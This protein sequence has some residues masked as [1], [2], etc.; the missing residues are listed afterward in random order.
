MS[1]LS[2]IRSYFTK[3][4]QSG[5]PFPNAWTGGETAYGQWNWHNPYANTA[6]NYKRAMGDLTGSSLLMAAVNWAGMAF[7]EA[8]LQV[9]E[10]KSAKIKEPIENHPMIDLLE[11]PTRYQS[12]NGPREYFA[13]EL[14]W[15]SFA[16]SYI[17]DGNVYFRKV[18]NNFG[19]VIQLWPENSSTIRP[20]WPKDGSE[21]ISYYEVIRNG[22]WYRVG[23]PNGTADDV[24]HFRYA[25]PTGMTVDPLNDRLALSPV[26]S[27]YREIFTDGE[28]A[29]YNALIFKNGGVIPFLLTPDPANMAGLKPKEIKE[30]F[31]YRMGGD[32][33]GRP[34]VLT[35]AAKLTAMGATPDQLLI[36][37][38][39]W[40]PATRVAAALGIPA[41]VLG[42]EPGLE[43]TKVG[44]PQP[45]SAR[46]WT[47]SGATTMG[48]VEVGDMVATP[49]GWNP[50]INT[51]DQGEQDIYR[52]T[53]QDSSTAESTIDHLWEVKSPNDREYRTLPLSKIAKFPWWKLRYTVLPLQGVTE[54]DEQMVMIPPYL[55]G[56]LISDGSFRGNVFF[57]NL[58]EEVVAYAKAEVPD[59][60][61]V[62]NIQFGDYLIS[63]RAASQG[64]GKG[65]GSGN[66]NPMKD[67]LRRLGLWMLYSYEKFIPDVYKYNSSEVR[68]DLLRGI[69]D[70]DGFVNQHGQPALEQTSLRLAQDVTWLVQSL[71][72]YTLQSLKKV[73]RNTRLIAGRP[74][75]SNHDRYHLSIVIDDAASLFRYSGKKDKC[76]PRIKPATRKF[77]SIELVRREET[78]CLQLEDGLYLTDSFLVTHNTMRELREQAA[79]SFL[80]PHYRVMAGELQS[81]LLPEFGDTK[82]LIVAHDLSQVRVLQDDRVALFEREIKA[83]DSGVKTRAEVKSAL[84]IDTTP[85][86]EVYK[87]RSNETLISPDERSA[88]VAVPAVPFGNLAQPQPDVQGKSV[89]LGDDELAG[90]WW[91]RYAPD[92]APA[93][94]KRVN[95][96]A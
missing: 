18:R 22:V 36:E 38:A 7:P 42:L 66:L 44:A 9:L 13:G 47:P 60:Y 54:F 43:Q 82:N 37:K 31:E 26:A 50:V 53:F 69:L 52:I 17:L 87:I 14:L 67:E 23:G 16:A 51:Y 11:H 40:I 63:Y 48:E 78:R 20:R 30:E 71:G 70:G 61:S 96:R 90:D 10:K 92:R 74:M 28:R 58:S 46:L 75:H 68:R 76:R 39:S 79:E 34:M 33:I 81:Q 12:K 6:I 27:L 95:G 1:L 64:K 89:D 21:W 65:N 94:P 55:L 73:N 59:G 19:E 83:Y 72:G 2:T 5:I 4:N 35:G 15:R 85:N 45:L 24:I 80:I 91:T 62:K 49:S 86:D 41:G 84:G 8:P 56:L 57:S 77:R 3:A 29:R 93:L 88:P 32:N 25:L